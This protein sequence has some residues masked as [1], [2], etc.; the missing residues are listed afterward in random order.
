MYSCRRGIANYKMRPKAYAINLCSLSLQTLQNNQGSSSLLPWR[1][2]TEIIVVQLC[3]RISRCCC[4]EGYLY[5]GFANC[6]GEDRI[7]ECT[8]AIQ[9][10]IH[11]IPCISLS[12]AVCNLSHNVLL[13]SC[14]KS[15]VRPNSNCNWR[16]RFLCPYAAALRNFLTP[17]WQL[18]APDQIVTPQ[19]LPILLCESLHS[20]SFGNGEHVRF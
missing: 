11:N 2:N 6:D 3:I 8:V 14:G 15:H 20:T 5:V 13:N 4:V 7:S 1:R 19:N 16:C 18:L 17:C 12:L 9:C 10:F